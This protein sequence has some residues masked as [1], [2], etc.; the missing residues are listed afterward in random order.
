M[1]AKMALPQG[2]KLFF[3][4][5]A[6]IGGIVFVVYCQ[7]EPRK[8]RPTYAPAEEIKPQAFPVAPGASVRQVT[9]ARPV[10]ISKIRYF[11]QPQ[12]AFRNEHRSVVQA[13][14]DQNASRESRREALYELTQMD[15]GE[16]LHALRTIARAPISNSDTGPKTDFEV[17]LRI[18]AL[19]S[20]D[21][22]R[23][24][25][26]EIKA[27]MTSVLRSQNHPTLRFLAQLSLEGQAEGRPGK[28]SRFIDRTLSGT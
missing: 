20:I 11:A 10:K 21:Q 5:A 15:S 25:P 24:S 22:S 13:V 2:F 9:A 26:D 23:R 14:L 4:V 17:S 16:S 1:P 12:F 7:S 8:S 18:T 6:T 3:T 27:A 28:L 19:E